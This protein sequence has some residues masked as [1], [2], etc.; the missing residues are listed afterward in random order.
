[1][2]G[3]FASNQK[4]GSD[5]SLD[6]DD[7]APSPEN[8][9]DI[10]CQHPSPT[11]L[12]SS[13]SP[14]R[15]EGER[16]DCLVRR[17]SEQTFVRESLMASA[18]ES[19]GYEANSTLPVN[20]TN[21]EPIEVDMKTPPYIPE[22][23][24]EFS[25]E[26]SSGHQTTSQRPSDQDVAH[27][28]PP[29][30]LDRIPNQPSD[31]IM[32]GALTPGIVAEEK[33]NPP[34]MSLNNRFPNLRRYDLM[35]K[36]IDNEEQCNIRI[37]RPAT[38][39]PASRIPSSIDPV[40]SA[41]PPKRSGRPLPFDT[42]TVLEVDEAICTQPDEETPSDILSLRDA[43]GPEGIRKLG[44][45]KY[46]TSLETAMRCKN[47]RKSAPRM[48]RRPKPKETQQRDARIDPASTTTPTSSTA[49]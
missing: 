18:M 5:I 31:P 25:N 3:S 22:F 33:R 14:T 49:A 6:D 46:R 10:P 20:S 26:S 35:A 44:H 2:P 43:R 21:S 9:P 34:E 28:L 7:P 4:M 29:Q 42:N 30:Q 8:I 24:N 47:M 45:L 13:Q 1:M 19:R 36:M 37:S 40:P 32:D 41:G 16:M 15:S 27:L 23:S 11:M 38:L 17:M 48:R 39:I 12:S